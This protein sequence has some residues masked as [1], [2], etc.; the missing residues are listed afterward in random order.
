M[1][2]IMKETN[3]VKVM[4]SNWI[5]GRYRQLLKEDLSEKVAFG[6]R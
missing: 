5:G 3:E 1:I 2:A 6:Q 4:E